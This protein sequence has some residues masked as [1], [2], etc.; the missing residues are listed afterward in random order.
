MT[1][2]V[3]HRAASE[4]RNTAMGPMSSGTPIRPSGI[5][6]AI[7]LSPSLLVRPRARVPSVLVAVGAITLTRMPLAASSLAITRDSDVSAL[8]V[9]V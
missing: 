6:L 8:L 7:E 1:S 2:P 9:A 4:A 3:I 5:W